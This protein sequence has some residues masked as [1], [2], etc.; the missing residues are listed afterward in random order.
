VAQAE[1]INM[2]NRYNGNK[3]VTGTLMAQLLFWGVAYFILLNIFSS[4]DEWMKIDYIYTSIFIVTLMITVGINFTIIMPR[5]LVPKKYALFFLLTGLNI[6]VGTLFNHVLFD[7][8]IDYI[9]PGY[10]F[11]S[12]YEYFDLLKFFFVFVTLA[13]LLH[14]SWEWF[15][16]QESRHRMTILE[17]EKANAELKA[18]TNQVNPHFL[19][20]SLTVLYSLSLENSPDTSGAIIKLSDILRYSLYE[21]AKGPV[22][23]RSEISLIQNYIDLQQYR[24]PMSAKISF[25]MDVS[26]EKIAIEPMLLLPLVENSYK[27]GIKNDIAN[28]FIDI[29]LKARANQIIFRISNNKSNTSSV[30][31][32][33]GGI[34]LSNIEERLKLIYPD[35]YSL[36][37]RETDSLFSVELKINIA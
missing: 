37:I 31:M 4:S 19:F 3:A 30:E 9:L 26:D 18:L 7:K 14:L 2:R 17:K 33:S 5:F 22:T 10:Y 8:L 23:L 12:Y 36:S 28:T 27:H 13:T 16:L 11:I 29:F 32:P 21:G 35:A 24:I 34:G 6:L 20:N 25:K 15:Q 1:K